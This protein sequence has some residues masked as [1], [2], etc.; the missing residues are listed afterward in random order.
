M[1]ERY[2]K[3]V[4]VDIP[5]GSILE[6]LKRIDDDCLA[7]KARFMDWFMDCNP[8]PAVCEQHQVS[9]EPDFE[10]S[11]T[12][13][14]KSGKDLVVHEQCPKCA[15]Q[16]AEQ[17]R[18]D[19]RTEWLVFRGVGED[20]KHAAFE[21]Y[22]PETANEGVILNTC[23]MWA[24]K[25]AGFLLFYG[26]IG[27]GKSHLMAS[28][29]RH[30]GVGRYRT[31]ERIVA[32]MRGGY[33][34][35]PAHISAKEQFERTKNSPLLCWDE[36]GLGA[37]GTDVPDMI[38]TIL[39]HRFEDY[40]PTVIGFNGPL[41]AFKALIGDRMESR[42]RERLFCEPLLFDGRD[43]REERGALFRKQQNPHE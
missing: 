29:L 30:A 23:R 20:V 10:A 17:A 6:Q 22:K 37:S 15:E 34:S 24:G 16:R 41:A 14:A 36:F 19:E 12:A 7:R 26:N 5:M 3:S 21:N 32:E 43:R 4:Q 13:S 31:H 40:L 9:M 8:Q 18:F 27:S 11:F 39:C 38:H 25:R 28:I 35:S 2:E 33:G 1:S 42:I